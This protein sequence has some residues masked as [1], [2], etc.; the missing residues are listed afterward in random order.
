VSPLETA[1]VLTGIAA[2]WLT[3]RQNLWCWPVGLVNVAIFAVVFHGA[4]LYADMG[5]QAIYAALG[6]YGWYHWLRGGPEG[7]ALPVSRAPL[8]AL[9]GLAAAGGLASC[10][11]GL[12]LARGTDAAVPF[13]DAATTSFSL[14]AQLMQARKWVENWIV[15]LIVDV[16]LVAKYAS[17][18]LRAT[19]GLYLVFLVL[20]SV[21][22]RSWSRALRAQRTP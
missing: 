21:G 16:A 19:A 18:G 10:A 3:T 14:V 20:A 8:R 22:L 17:L 1:G 6:A 12:G 2:V 13:W 5:L 4:R 15:W 7:V 9:L 11:L